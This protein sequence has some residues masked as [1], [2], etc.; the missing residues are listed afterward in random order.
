MKLND[1]FNEFIS[2]EKSSGIA[3]MICGIISLFAANSIFGN[4]YI[5]LWHMK[6][7]SKSIEFWIN[8]GLMT[9]FFLLVGLEIEREFYIGELSDIKKSLLPIFAAA[10]GMLFPA[11]I[12]FFL[13]QNTVF[14]KGFGI[15]MATDIAFSLGVLSLLGRRVVSSLKVFLTAQAIIDDLGAILVIALFYSNSLSLV[16]LGAAAVIF[17]IMIILNRIKYYRLFPYLILGCVMWGCMYLSGI[18]PTITGVLLAFAIPFSRGDKSSPSHILQ[19][20]LHKIVAFIILPI[21]ALANTA[22][23]I[24]ADFTSAIFNSNSYGIILGLIAG[25]PLGIF[26]FSLIG[27]SLG[28]C[29]LPKEIKKI[30]LIGIGLL[31]GIGFTMS[32]FITLL[33][34]SSNVV[35][36]NS[37]LSVLIASVAAGF[38][39]FILLHF[40]LPK[41]KLLDKG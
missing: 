38:L 19:H 28:L 21:F 9:I 6:I 15:P 29:A 16:Y 33:A 17:A 41:K 8:D 24:P 37:K 25:K 10:G 40:T 4:E 13:N 35:I 12:H 2:S 7:F 11:A 39:G 20:R 31:A 32:I 5:H 3:L 23:L 27:I 18:H 14:S 30:H 26:L 22:I 1:L 36:V 34:F